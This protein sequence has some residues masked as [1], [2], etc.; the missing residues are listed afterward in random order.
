MCAETDNANALMATEGDLPISG[1]CGAEQAIYNKP[2]SEKKHHLQGGY[3]CIFVRHPPEILQTECP[4]CLCVL[5]DPY[6]IDCCGNSFC[7]TCIE[8]IKEESKPCPLCNVQFTATMPDK[9]LQRTL[10]ELQVYC[11]HKEAGCEWIGELGSLTQHLNLNSQ[12]EGDR[13]IGCQLVC[14]ECAFCSEDIQR[15][16]IEEHEE[17]TCPERPYN[18]EY[19]QEYE[20][21]HHDVKANHWPV[22][23]FRPVPCPNQCGISPKLKVLDDH[24]QN[25]CPLRVIDCAFKYAGCKE[26]MPRKD[27]PDHITESLALHM[28]LQATNHQQE[29]KKLTGRISELEIQLDEARLELRELKA[30]NYQS[31]ETLDLQCRNRVAAVGREIKLAQELRLKGHLGTLRGEIKKAQNE[32]K[33]EIMKQVESEITVVHNHVGLV[34]V[35]FTMPDFQQKKRSNTPWYSPSFYTHPR[36]YKMCLRIEANG[37]GPNEGNHVGAALFMMPGDYDE[38]LKW[39]FRGDITLQLLNQLGD[40]EHLVKTLPVTDYAVDKFCNRVI[41][42][43][44][45][46][47]G[48]GI[49]DFISHRNLLPKYLQNDCLKVCV[50]EVKIKS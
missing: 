34:P 33:Q 18:C 9:R 3:E 1:D 41:S 6:L 45:S 20:S 40:Y 42:G 26:R 48:W 15:K 46:P 23:P 8:P 7:R 50:Q 49:P 12:E 21:T 27:M 22:C 30:E 37:W 2:V 39:P 25:D 4:I 5:K 17:D 16:D 28:S 44:R 47:S 38:I 31:K 35:S 14:I 19:C 11:S 13:L 29:L 32:A 24:I 36:G 10:N 43:E